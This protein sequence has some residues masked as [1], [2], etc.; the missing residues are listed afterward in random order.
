MK[1]DYDFSFPA[2]LEVDRFLYKKKFNERN[3]VEQFPAPLEV[4]RFLYKYAPWSDEIVFLFPS[5]S[6]VDR[7]FYLRFRKEYWCL[8]LCV[9]IP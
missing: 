8:N 1:I 6:E 9:S 7:L 4:D 3:W 5:P 2:P